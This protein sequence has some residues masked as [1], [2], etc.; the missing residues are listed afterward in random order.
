[1]YILYDEYLWNIYEIYN[2]WNF[3]LIIYTHIHPFI[4]VNL[5]YLYITVTDLLSTINLITNYY[6]KT[7]YLL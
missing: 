5:F 7:E 3:H 2:L 4:H 6:F 1:M